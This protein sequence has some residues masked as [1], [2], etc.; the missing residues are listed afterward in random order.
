MIALMGM[1]IELD[2]ELNAD[3]LSPPSTLEFLQ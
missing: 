2:L 3:L 1:P